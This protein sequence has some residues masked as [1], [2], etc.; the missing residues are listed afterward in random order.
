MLSR[1]RSLRGESPTSAVSSKAS[2]SA[3]EM[4]RNLSPEVEEEEQ[5]QERNESDLRL[6]NADDDDDDDEGNKIASNEGDVIPR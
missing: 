5:G 6:E 1:L 3:T 2:S 4:T